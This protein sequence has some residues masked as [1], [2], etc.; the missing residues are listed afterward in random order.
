MI[1]EVRDANHQKRE[2]RVKQDNSCGKQHHHKTDRA[3]QLAALDARDVN[4]YVAA[5]ALHPQFNRCGD[6]DRQSHHAGCRRLGKTGP[7]A[8]ISRCHYGYETAAEAE[9]GIILQTRSR[10][11]SGHGHSFCRAAVCGP[12]SLIDDAPT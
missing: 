12:V 11:P 8:H 1:L 2:P 10:R 9:E 5:A 3:A 4:I 6:T 7:T